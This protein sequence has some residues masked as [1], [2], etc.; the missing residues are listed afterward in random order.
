MYKA[1]YM[2]R[3]MQK[4]YKMQIKSNIIE[5]VVVSKTDLTNKHYSSKTL[6]MKS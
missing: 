6:N 3:K 4:Y 1:K 2:A 5:A